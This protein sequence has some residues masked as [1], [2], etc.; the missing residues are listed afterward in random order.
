MLLQGSLLRHD[1]VPVVSWVRVGGRCRHCGGS[2]SV[3]YLLVE[4]ATAVLVAA[5]FA[6]FGFTGQAFL[7]AFFS[8][9][10]VTLAAIDAERRILPDRIVL[11]SAAIVLAGNLVLEPEL[12][13]EWILAPLALSGFLFAV[14]LAYPRGM[15]MGDVK[16][17]LL[18]GAGLGREV[19]VAMA[20]AL[21]SGLV[22]SIVLL[23]REGRAARKLKVPFGVFMALGGV[24]AL[25]AGERLLD[26]YLTLF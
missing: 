16:L 13:L 5:C 2:I 14:L 8:A 18:L 3:R 10:L 1:N 25:F 19:A 21:L 4:L 22:V 24:V 6:R 23:V 17:A 15:G 26:A 9:V 20:V 11:P 7:A 12:W